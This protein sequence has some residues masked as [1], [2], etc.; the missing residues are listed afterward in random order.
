M[1]I[2]WTLKLGTSFDLES[3]GNKVAN[4]T[5]D[6][7]SLPGTLNTGN[8]ITATSGNI[9]ATSGYIGNTSGSID[10]DGNI[11]SKGTIT[12]KNGETDKITLKNDGTITSNGALNTNGG[13]ISSGG[14]T[15]SG[16]VSCDTVNTTTFS[17]DSLTA[18]TLGV[19]DKGTEFKVD[20]TGALT[21]SKILEE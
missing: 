15:S 2:K 4:F 19:G 6:S 16:T 18:K 1:A 9:T 20:A 13:S 10:K 14:I 8:T 17:T 12:V 21:A 3:G 11:L 7:A 5:K